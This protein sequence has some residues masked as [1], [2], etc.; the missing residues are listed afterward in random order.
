[1][2]HVRL[3]MLY[4]VSGCDLHH[5][6]CLLWTNNGNAVFLLS[7]EFQKLSFGNVRVLGIHQGM[8]V[9]Q[10]A[11]NGHGKFLLPSE[12]ARK[13]SRIILKGGKI[14][15][16]TSSGLFLDNLCNKLL[17]YFLQVFL[18]SVVSISHKLQVESFF[19][20]EFQFVFSFTGICVRNMGWMFYSGLSGKWV[21]LFCEG[22]HIQEILSP[23]ASNILCVEAIVW[24]VY[25]CSLHFTK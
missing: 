19:V 2:F 23:P 11:V 10:T 4:G 21:G 9:L 5:T 22:S 14:S 20:Q 7:F 13:E 12:L 24:T 8:C 15:F 18:L 1:M 16:R 17:R 25:S 6:C 3:L